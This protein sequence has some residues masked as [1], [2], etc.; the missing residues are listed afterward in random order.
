MAAKEK[1]APGAMARA[2]GVVLA[3]E[4]DSRKNVLVVTKSQQRSELWSWPLA[5]D[6]VEARLALA[7]AR[8]RLEARRRGARR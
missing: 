8:A 4:R 2:S 3:A 6:P 1:P 5:L 7:T